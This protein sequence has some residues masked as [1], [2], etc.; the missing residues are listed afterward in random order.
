[1]LGNGASRNDTD[2]TRRPVSQR[3]RPDAPAWRWLF[4][5]AVALS[6]VILFTP[7]DHVPHAPIGV[8]KVVHCSLFAALAV[9]GALAGV[10]RGWLAVALLAYA[11]ASEVIQTLP[12]LARDGS[13]FDALAD[14]SGVALGLAVAALARR[15]QRA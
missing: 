3:F 11:A 12:V 14:A 13:V 15:R 2:T 5:L 6:L 4:G 1:M 9:T 7:G 8:D 10:R